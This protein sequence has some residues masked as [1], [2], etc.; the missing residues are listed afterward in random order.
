MYGSLSAPDRLVKR[1]LKELESAKHRAVDEPG[2]GGASEPER[3][4]AFAFSMLFLI[5]D[6]YGDFIASLWE[7]KGYIARQDV[8]EVQSQ[9][10]Q[11]VYRHLGDAAAAIVGG[12]KKRR[13]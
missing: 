10:R 11:E 8:P 2:E 5:G 9:V 4:P 3:Y 1:A 6:I 13:L 7:T 12:M